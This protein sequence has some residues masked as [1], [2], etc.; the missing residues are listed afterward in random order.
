[1]ITSLLQ[2]PTVASHHI[3]IYMCVFLREEICFKE[4]KKKIEKTFGTIIYKAEASSSNSF[5]LDK[6]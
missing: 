6:R 4:G 2:I 3:Y 5:I 1:M